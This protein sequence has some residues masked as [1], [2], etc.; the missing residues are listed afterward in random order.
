MAK[1]RVPK[2]LRPPERFGAFVSRAGS[3]NHLSVFRVKPPGVFRVPK[4]DELFW[5]AYCGQVVISCDGDRL[6]RVI[7]ERVK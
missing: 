2:E 3:E 4:P 6:E 1:V 7:V 5:S